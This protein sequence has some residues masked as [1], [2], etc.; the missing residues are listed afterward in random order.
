MAA[1]GH[2]SVY[3]NPLPSTKNNTH[4]SRRI[5]YQLQGDPDFST[6]KTEKK[7]AALM[8]HPKVVEWIKVFWSLF[9]VQ[10]YLPDQ[11]TKDP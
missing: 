6:D 10:Q 5:P 9:C 11:G 2:R 1:I 4:N 8:E 7:R 3:A